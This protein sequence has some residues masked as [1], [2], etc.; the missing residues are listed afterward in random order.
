[1]ISCGSDHMAAL[2]GDGHIYTWGCGGNGR[3][4]HGTEVDLKRPQRVEAL[5]DVIT[6]SCGG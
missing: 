4:G 2:T 1:M 3:L 6:V 5:S